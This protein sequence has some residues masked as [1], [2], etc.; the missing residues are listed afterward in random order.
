M[1]KKISL[2]FPF[3]LLL[4][5]SIACGSTEDP[6]EVPLNSDKELLEYKIESALNPR[7][8]NEDIIGRIENNKIFLSFPYGI[9]Q[10]SLVATFSH[11]GKEVTV[12]G[13]VQQSGITSNNFKYSVFYN[14]TAEDGSQSIYTVVTTIIPPIPHIYIDTPNKNDAIQKEEYIEDATITIEANGWGEDYNG[15]TKIKGRGNSTW[16]MPKKPYRLKLDKK[17]SL[18]KL[19]EEKD[20]VLLANYIDPTLMLNAIAFKIGQLLE[21]PYTNHAVPVDLTLNGEYMGN[22]LLTE[23]VEISSSRVDIDENNGVLLELDTNYDEDYKF[24]SN[25]FHLPV[26]VKDPDLEESQLS[27]EQIKNDFHQLEGAM[28]AEEFPD[29]NYKNYIDIESVVKY[30]IVYNLTHNMEINHPKSVYLHK[31]N[32]GKYVMGPI[33][34]FDW[35]YDYEGT[36]KHFGSYNRKFLQKFSHS[37]A[38]G[39]DFFSRFFEDPEVVT[40]YQETWNKFH[41]EKKQELMEYIDWYA[42]RITDSQQKDYQRWGH[43]ATY[44]KGTVNQLKQWLN[45]RCDYMDT[46]AVTQW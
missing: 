22:Y 30:L 11:N 31:E 44:F 17:A 20:W 18:F 40:L 2:L 33:W 43:G 36:Q 9:D 10:S 37:D 25:F 8:S 4:F 46:E 42:E 23:Q 45:N 6:P 15:V 27:L 34:D 12:N 38:T 1:D 13:V 7:L 3:C 35:A 16:G 19:N 21:I 39:F 32:G 14:I 28:A 41:S 5:I 24:Y 26:M 29:N